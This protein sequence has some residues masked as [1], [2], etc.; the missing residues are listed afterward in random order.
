VSVFSHIITLAGYMYMYL[1]H[2]Y[3]TDGIG[4]PR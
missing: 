2:V 1:V 4:R 3:I